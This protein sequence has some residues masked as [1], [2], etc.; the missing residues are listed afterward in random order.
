MIFKKGQIARTIR[1]E[2]A[3]TVFEE[4]LRALE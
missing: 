3:D 2:E 1:P 4:E